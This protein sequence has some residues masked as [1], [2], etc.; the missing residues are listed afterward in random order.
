MYTKVGERGGR[1]SVGQRQ[2]LTFARAL[3]PN[4]KILILDEAT[5][6]IDPQTE[7]QI[8]RA[9]DEMLKNRTSIIIAHRLST[10][11]KADWILVLNN[12]KII[13]EGS[14][15]TLID[16]KGEFYNLYQLQFNSEGI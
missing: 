14:F 15:E 13:E 10:V 6:S 12:G 4:P 16:M 2:L 3:I 5:S 9:M 11:R 1:L 7:L 8:Q